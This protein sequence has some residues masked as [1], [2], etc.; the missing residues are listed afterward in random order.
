MSLTLINSFAQ[1][2]LQDEQATNYTLAHNLVEHASIRV[3]NGKRRR[4]GGRC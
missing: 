2:E 3:S 1:T 4:A